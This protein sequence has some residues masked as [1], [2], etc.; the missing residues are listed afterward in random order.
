MI[1]DSP[2]RHRIYSTLIGVG[3]LSAITR[4]VG[5]FKDLAVGW[6]YGATS[7]VDQY[8]GIFALAT[9]PAAIWQSILNLVLLPALTQKR[10]DPERTDDSFIA[11]IKTA[12]RYASLLIGTVLSVTVY[13][14]LIHTRVFQP[15]STSLIA[16]ALQLTA[17]AWIIAVMSFEVALQNTIVIERN[18]KLAT[19]AEAIPSIAV[20]GILLAGGETKANL[21]LIATAVGLT[22]QANIY[23]K[24][25]GWSRLPLK[26]RLTFES[27]HWQRFKKGAVTIVIGQV[28]ASSITIIDQLMAITMPSGSL[29]LMNYA[30]KISLL[31][32]VIG[33][34]AITRT[35]LP[36]FAAEEDRNHGAKSNGPWKWLIHAVAAGVASSL[37]AWAIAVIALPSIVTNG[38]LT[39]QQSSEILRLLKYS[40]AQ[41]PPYFGCMLLVSSLAARGAYKRIAASGAMNL[42]VK[43]IIL[44]LL[45]PVRELD[46]IPQS[47]AAMYWVSLIGLIVM[48][49][50]ELKKRK[51]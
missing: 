36:A 30:S 27:T 15:N 31:V 48:T 6:R 5:A 32:N 9:W 39:A 50:A 29:T 49:K 51:L 28:F 34:T 37:T 10:K 26:G 20:L 35:F 46:K 2:R 40:L 42:T 14:A 25:T 24:I 41:V 3:I 38:K 13:S 16:G 19:A 17:L 11:E 22:L 45:F 18:P 43:G 12:N 33:A 47:T 1:K 23:W 21:P 8:I 7:Q 4:G 44:I